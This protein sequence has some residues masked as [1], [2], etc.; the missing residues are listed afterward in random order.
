M[1]EI[2]GRKGNVTKTD[3]H[4]T[5]QCCP[6]EKIEGVTRVAWMLCA[7]VS[8]G[9]KSIPISSIATYRYPSYHTNL[10][11]AVSTHDFTSLPD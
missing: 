11:W 3:T 10:D 2:E 4:N 1:I 9:E 5:R 6:K 7:M 8:A